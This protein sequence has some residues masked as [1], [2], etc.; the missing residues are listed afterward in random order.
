MYILV[1][2]PI[3]LCPPVPMA[4]CAGASLPLAQGA[5]DNEFLDLG[6]K[7]ILN[8]LCMVYIHI[9][10]ILNKKEFDLCMYIYTHLYI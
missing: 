9:D 10:R 4:P 1:R 2:S 3:F 8:Y 6:S 5:Q 7:H